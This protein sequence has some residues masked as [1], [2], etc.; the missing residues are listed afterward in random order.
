[1]DV[2]RS[3]NDSNL[4]LPAGDVQ[5]GPLDYNIYTNS[6]LRT[7][8]EIDQLPL[9]MVGQTPVRVARYRLRAGCAAD[10]NQHRPRGWPA[11]V[12][13]PVLKQGGDTNTI[14]VVDGVKEALKHLFDVPK[15]LGHR[16]WCSINRCS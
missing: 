16:R 12:Y 7:V 3:V 6:Q 9:K 5:I 10:P 4:I 14:A 1:M 15:Q 11:S 13:I 8:G 2:V